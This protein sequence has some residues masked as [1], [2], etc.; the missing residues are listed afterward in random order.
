MGFQLSLITGP[1]SEPVTLAE[2]K[3]WSRV[4]IDDDNDLLTG[5]IVAARALVE[6]RARITVVNQTRE[7][8]LSGDDVPTGSDV[9]RLPRGPLVSVT[10]AKYYTGGVLTTWSSAN[11]VAALGVPGLIAPAVGQ[12][13]PTCDD[14]PDALA[15]RYGCG[16]GAALVNVPADVAALVRVAMRLLIAHWYAN[17]ETVIVGSISAAI[18]F[19]VDALLAPLADGSYH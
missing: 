9:V 7:L 17:R 1:A 3:A 5:L 16:H 2:A 4:E 10:S 18:E 14:R 12:S 13:W 8:V 19:T 15:I 11:Y 6:A